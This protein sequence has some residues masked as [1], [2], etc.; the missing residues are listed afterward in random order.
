MNTTLRSI[1]KIVVRFPILVDLILY[2]KDLPTRDFFDNRMKIKSLGGGI[3]VL[4]NLL[5]VVIIIWR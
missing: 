1:K 4:I 3:L 2:I 5:K